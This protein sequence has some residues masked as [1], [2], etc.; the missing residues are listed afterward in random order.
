MLPDVCSLLI[1]TPTGRAEEPLQ[2][3]K[4][5]GIHKT[6]IVFDGMYCLLP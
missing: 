2:K 6:L 5:K 1:V 3:K 4:R